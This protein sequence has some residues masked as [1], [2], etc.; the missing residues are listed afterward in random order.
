L[1]QETSVP[2]VRVT[3]P[4]GS[5]L[6]EFDA[7]IANALPHIGKGTIE[8]MVN[9]EGVLFPETYFFRDDE[10]AEEIVATLK[11]EEAAR[12]AAIEPKIAAQDLSRDEVI[13]VAS[14][15]EQEANDETSMRLVS[16]ILRKRLKMGMALQVDATLY[17]LLGKQS[18]ELTPEDLATDSPFNTYLYPGL[19]PSPI[20]SP[21]MMAIEAALNPESSPYLYYLTDSEGNFHYA[22]TFEQHKENKERYLR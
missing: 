21:G 2:A 14:L 9:A 4:E 6:A 5:T 16:G 18:H 17:Y 10:K 20:N 1:R 15:L 13:I 12:L 8:A 22:E 3:I 19:P 7:I 11:G